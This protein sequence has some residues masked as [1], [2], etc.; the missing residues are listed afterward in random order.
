MFVLVYP[1]RSNDSK[2]FFARKYYLPKGII[3]GHNATVRWI[4][5]Y[6]IFSTLIA[7]DLSR[8]KELDAVPKATEQIKFVR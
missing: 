1:N 6:K 5:H 8:Q 3:K 4:L 7:V 2:R